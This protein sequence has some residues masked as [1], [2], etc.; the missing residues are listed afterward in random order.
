MYYVRPEKLTLPKQLELIETLRCIATLLIV[1]FHATELFRLKFEEYFLFSIF[2]FGDS[3][4]DFF[5]VLSGFSLAISSSKYIGDTS[6][7]KVFLLKRFIRIYPLYWI[8]SALIVPIYF[9]I[10]S[11]GNGHE[12]NVYSIINSFLL[13]PYQYS[14]ILIVAWF[15]SHITFFY[16]LFSFLILR[17]KIFSYLIICWLFLSIMF[18]PYD[19]INYLYLDENA[20]RL[21]KFFFSY[22]NLE[23]AAGYL[24]AMLS[25]IHRVDAT[26]SLYILLIGCA[27]FLLGGLVEVFLSHSFSMSSFFYHYYEFIIYGSSSILIVAG[28]AFLESTLQIHSNKYFLILGSASFSIYLVHYAVLSA[29]TKIIQFTNVENLVFLSIGMIMACVVAVG[30]GCI[31]HF[32]VE[33]RISLLLRKA[34]VK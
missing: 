23:F 24:I 25:K 9:F 14:P 18:I 21:I 5:F 20:H 6:K 12:T 1:F 17:P 10:P 16:I 15:L 19:L 32:C 11:F 8:I 31:V 13:I 34:L 4:V 22:Y 28:S 33:K 27:G 7:V 2:S 30:V 29:L 26:T 3:G